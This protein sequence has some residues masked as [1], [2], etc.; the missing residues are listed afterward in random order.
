VTIRQYIKRRFLNLAL[1]F[2]LP[3][4]LLQVIRVCI[5]HW[6]KAFAAV[7]WVSVVAATPIFWII[8]AWFSIK[9]IGIPCPR[10]LHLLRGTA[11]AVIIGNK[12][13]NRCPH[14]HVS[15]DEPV[16]PINPT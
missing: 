1:I 2:V 7:P 3:Y 11:L 14:C 5:Q 13:I 4:A 16:V 15:L 6:P 8:M 9:V 12:K 10:C